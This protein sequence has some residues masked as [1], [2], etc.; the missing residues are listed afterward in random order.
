M[1][2]LIPV[3]AIAAALSM[4]F[5]GLAAQRSGGD[6]ASG[7]R[8]AQMCNEGSRDIAGLPVDQFQRIIGSDDAKR[9][10]LDDLAN[11]AVK[12]AQDIKAACPA[13]TPPTAPLRLAAMR[14]RIEAMIAAVATVQ[15]ELDKFYGLLSDEQ[16]EEVVALGDTQRQG[17]TASLLDQDCGS[18]QP[19]GWPTAEVERAVHP[20]E[21]QRPSLLALQ[22]ATSKAA[23]L[24]KDSCPSDTPLTPTARLA[25]VGKRLEA[26]QQA[27]NTVIPP[28]D[29]FYAMLDDGQKARFNGISL[30]KTAQTEQPKARPAM[31]HR[32]HYL[33]VG[34]MIRRFLRLF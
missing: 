22:E 21:A 25:A 8:L 31:V 11:A 19:S 6:G 28:L 15:P 29:D 14:T 27:V 4:P 34:A 2:H 20:T 17:R 32:H 7:G 13:G 18:G 30:P 5:D 33:N 1:R 9:A 23:D 26:L 3:A 12:A 10:A 24:A 16:K